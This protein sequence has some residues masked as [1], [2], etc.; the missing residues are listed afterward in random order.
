[1]SDVAVKWGVLRRRKLVDMWCS[2]LVKMP[3]GDPCTVSS[4]ELNVTA[5]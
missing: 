4:V 1:M 5:E 3:V 2:P